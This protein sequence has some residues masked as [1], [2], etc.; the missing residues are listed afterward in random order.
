MKR[1]CI[2]ALAF[3]LTALFT[4]AAEKPLDPVMGIYDG[5]W[6]AK[7]GKKGRVTG[8]IR[9]IGGGKY[10]GFVEFY[11]AKA[12][13]GALK[14]VSA[15]DG[16][17]KF[18]GEAIKDVEGSLLAQIDGSCEVKDGKMTGVLS[19]DL[20]EG[21]FEA[22]LTI[23]ESPTMGAKPP[24]MGVVLFDGKS[25]NAWR[26]FHWKITPEGSMIVNGGDIH[27][28][29]KYVNYNLHL[30]FKTPFMPNQQGQARGN[31]GAFLQNRYE[32][33]VLDSFG[34]FP[35]K[36]NDCSALYS[37][38]APDSNACFPPGQWQ[39]YDIT[40]VQGNAAHKELP[41]VTVVHNGATVIEKFEIPTA[42]LEKGTGGDG[43][44]D[45]FLRLQDHGNPVEY[46]NIWVEPFFA[47][48]RK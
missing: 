45:G 13:E 24:A 6:T 25:T 39:T 33:Q 5:F 12:R 44:E 41:T 28:R 30:E 21:T 10:D 2:S 42:I 17:L 26:D 4:T 31:S 20:G 38:K 29:E 9:P 27:T 36:N 48:E 22:A 16:S 11:R 23:H 14:L 3:V 19:G 34:L 40:F 15:G 35:L 32:V 7:D 37:V 43:K 8:Q 46:R 47:A 18:K 1:I